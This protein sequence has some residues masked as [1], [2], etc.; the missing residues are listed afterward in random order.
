MAPDDPTPE[1]TPAPA[2]APAPAEADPAPA[3]PPVVAPAPEPA[4]EQT[5]PL[6]RLQAVIAQKAE[7]ERAREA[8]AR[9]LKLANDTLEEFRTLGSKQPNGGDNSQ[10]RPAPKAPSPQEL[11]ALVSQEAERQQF[12]RRCNDS[13]A[14]GRKAHQDFDKV[15]LGDLTSISPVVAQNGRPVL[16]TSLVEAALETGS[17]HEILYAL[18]QD[19]NEASRIMA[20]R[21]VAQAVELAK[22]ASKLGATKTGE[23]GETESPDVSKAPPPIKAPTKG[24]PVRPAF[25]VFDTDHFSTEE[26]IKQR[27]RQIADSR[28]NR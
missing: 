2:P 7:T 25:N 15:V 12:D 19:I 13:V 8:L 16:P 10:A 14:E 23:S 24:G 11:Q 26:W 4:K 3:N 28:A 1:P 27:E 9:E 5:V 22:F 20:L 18:G 17:A 6:T 21:P